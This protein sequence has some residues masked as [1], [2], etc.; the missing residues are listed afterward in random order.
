MP[1][2]ELALNDTLVTDLAPLTS[3]TTLTSLQLINVKVSKETVAALQKALPNC[4]IGW[5]ETASC[6]IALNFETLDARRRLPPMGQGCADAAADKQIEAVSKKLVE[7]N[8]GFDGMLLGR[9]KKG[10]PT[11]QDGVVKILNFDPRFVTDLSPLRGFAGLVDLN[12]GGTGT[13]G[14]V[15]DLSPLA[16]LPLTSI[17]VTSPGSK[18]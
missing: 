17:S 9:D 8:P 7:L 1:L 18:T 16:G 6:D 14:R 4:K 13:R 5:T 15:Q 11:I 3:S 2:T 12:C 10:A